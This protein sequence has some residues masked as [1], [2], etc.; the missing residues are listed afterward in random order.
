MFPTGFLHYLS[1]FAVS[2]C[3]TC[4]TRSSCHTSPI[5]G[6]QSQHLPCDSKS[7][8]NLTHEGS[9]Y[10]QRKRH[11]G[12]SP[13]SCVSPLLRLKK[14]PRVILRTVALSVVPEP[15]GTSSSGN[16]LEMQILRPHLRP[17]EPET[18][19]GGD[20]LTGPPGDS[21]MH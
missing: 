7:C 9:E 13:Q 15:S 10:L 3:F 18:L 17:A 21:D 19:G 5:T 11:L 1:C 2:C 16:L 4:E 8:A 6:L 20:V 14:N 12:L